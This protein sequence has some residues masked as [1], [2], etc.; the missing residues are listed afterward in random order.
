[1]VRIWSLIPLSIT[2]ISST[3]ALAQ[4]ADANLNSIKGIAKT[5]D[6]MKGTGFSPYINSP[7]AAPALA[8]EGQFVGNAAQVPT[9]AA[10]PK[11]PPYQYI[12]SGDQADLVAPPRPG[13]ALMGGGTDQDD[14]FR[15][16][17]NHANG[18]DF[19]VLRASGDDAY[20]AYIQGLCKL[21]SVATL[22]IPSREAALDSKIAPFAAE[23]I[24]HAEA[25]FIA[26]GDQANYINFW[27]GTQVQ[28]ALNAAIRRGVPLG[29]T[30]AGLAVMGEWAYSA[31]G[32]KPD[33][34]NLDGKT[35][36]SDANGPRITLVHGFLNIPVLKGIIT[37]S[38]FAKRNRMGRLLVFL[39]H[40]QEPDGNA[41]PIPEGIHGIGIDERGAV[42]V[43][44]DGQATVAGKTN[45]WFVTASNNCGI[46]GKNAA[47]LSCGPIPV[48]RVEPGH[49]FDLKSW[50]PSQPGDGKSYTLSVDKGAIHS[51]QSDSS[52]Y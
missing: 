31:Q 18:G 41:V 32:D 9:S 50:T 48:V 45:A 44:P 28:T 1:M 16:L 26:G 5:F 3:F 47:M 52:I 7:G 43:E 40:I 36:L 35:A 34:P 39:A 24:A 6:S 30:S 29:G 21:N 25:I 13:Y 11:T 22:I 20:D 27:M 17:C 46:A 8:A 51:S 42:L 33:D 14:A 2:L 19:L 10:A 37:D 15:W 4:H 23:T 49:H 12:R 38:H